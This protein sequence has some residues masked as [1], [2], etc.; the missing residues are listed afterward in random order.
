M[1][2]AGGSSASGGKD[3]IGEAKKTAQAF[4][5]SNCVDKL[6]GVYEEV[7]KKEPDEY[8]RDESPWRKS[9]EQIKTEW[10]LLSNITTAVGNSVYKGEDS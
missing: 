7:L 9:V 3:F 1:A 8:I 2:S 6:A 10:D 5:V 4:S